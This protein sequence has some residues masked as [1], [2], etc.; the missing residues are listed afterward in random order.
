MAD[1]LRQ[2]SRSRKLKPPSSETWLSLIK[3]LSDR[4][5]TPSVA[6]ELVRDYPP[7]LIE[8]QMEVLDRLAANQGAGI[9][10]QSGWVSREVDS[11][12]LC[13]ASKIMAKRST[14]TK[15]CDAKSESRALPTRGSS[16]S[17]QIN[18]YLQSLSKHELDDAGAESLAARRD[19]HLVEGYQRSQQAVDAAFAVYRRMVLE[20]GAKRRLF[21]RPAEPTKCRVPEARHLVRLPY[22]P[23]TML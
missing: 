5:V 15:V 11:R 3:R 14:V 21:S 16:C 20:R 8:T 23:Q 7:E 12:R 19:Q 6:T 10:S 18:A 1:R 9:D 13:T 4:G 22:N 17:K 2:E